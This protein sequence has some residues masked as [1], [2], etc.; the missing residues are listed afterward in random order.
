M[1]K[2][3]EN[4]AIQHQSVNNKVNVTSICSFYKLQSYDLNDILQKGLY[5]IFYKQNQ[6]RP[7]GIYLR[8]AIISW[9]SS[10]GQRRSNNTVQAIQFCSPASKTKACLA[11]CGTPGAGARRLSAHSTAS[12]L[13]ASPYPSSHHRP[14]AIID[15]Y[16]MLGIPVSRRQLQTAT[17]LIPTILN[18]N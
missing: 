12:S 8:L 3:I 10:N 13:T 5:Y 6:F 11:P 1:K 2:K 18:R 7:S 15:C 4:A 9:K 16:L 14:I 17:L